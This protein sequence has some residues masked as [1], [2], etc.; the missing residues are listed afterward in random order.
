MLDSGEVAGSYD[1][2]LSFISQHR[3]RISHD[4]AEWYPGQAVEFRRDH[5]NIVSK[6]S[7]LSAFLPYETLS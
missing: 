4:L 5:V 2:F 3:G 1:E 7:D 6:S